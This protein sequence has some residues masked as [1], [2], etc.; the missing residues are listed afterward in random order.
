MLPATVAVFSSFLLPIF[1]TYLD[2][3][4][5]Y[6]P[7]PDGEDP[8]DPR[9]IDGENSIAIGKAGYAES[10]AMGGDGKEPWT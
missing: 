4:A 5:N 1:Y 9:A 10:P 6:Q 3:G 7:A 2:S 8:D